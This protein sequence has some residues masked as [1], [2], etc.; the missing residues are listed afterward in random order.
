V[1]YRARRA[2][3]AS[4]HLARSVAF[5]ATRW[6][7]HAS[8]TL[9][10]VLT[11]AHVDQLGVPR[12]APYPQLLEPPDADPHVRWCGRDRQ[13][14]VPIRCLDY[15][16]SEMALYDKPVRALMWDVVAG[17]KLRKG[18][19]ITRDQVLEWFTGH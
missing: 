5:G 4:D 3:G 17:L 8:V 18:D 13:V 16:K 12:L 7:H 15:M 1:N 9:H 11:N 10:R 2:L 19:V 6:W 14:T